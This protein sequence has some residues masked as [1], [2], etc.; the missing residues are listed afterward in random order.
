MV[1]DMECPICNTN[2]YDTDIPSY[3]VVRWDSTNQSNEL[4]VVCCSLPHLA[5]WLEALD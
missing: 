3:S 1:S 2:V 5:E 4:M